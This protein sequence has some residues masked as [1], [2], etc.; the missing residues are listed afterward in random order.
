MSGRS[1]QQFNLIVMLISRKCVAVFLLVKII[2]I[3]QSENHHP[4]HTAD[5][6][7]ITLHARD[8]WRASEVWSAVDLVCFRFMVFNATFNN[9]SAISSR[10]VLLVKETRVSGENHRPDG[11]HWQTLSHNVASSTPRHE[12]GS[13]LQL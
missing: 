11:S 13:S 6:A 3:L 9:I 7:P 12:R 5:Q 8:E 1:Y 10:S 4:L 2:R